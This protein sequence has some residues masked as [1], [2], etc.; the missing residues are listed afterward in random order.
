MRQFA[1]I[2]TAM[3]ATCGGAQAA[4]PLRLEAQ[5]SLTRHGVRPPTKAMPMPV[6]FA[7]DAWPG[8]P[9][10]PGFLTPHGAKAM[11]ELGRY[12]RALLA[13]RGLASV[14][15]C[16]AAGAVS[17]WADV[18]ERTIKSAEAWAQGFAPGCGLQAGHDPGKRDPLFSPIA[19]GTVAVDA[20]AAAKA[21]QAQAASAGGIEAIQA[22]QRGTLKRLGEVYGCCTAPICP[23]ASACKLEDLPTGLDAPPNQ[24]PKL[25]GALDLASTAAQIVL[26]EYAD[27]RPMAEVG[28]G[29][30]SAKDI[31]AFGAF[32]AIEFDLLARNPYI[33]ARNISPIAARMLAALEAPSSKRGTGKGPRI[34]V[35]LGHDTNVASLG[36]LLGLHWHIPGYA[37]DDPSP[38]GA[39]G[40]ERLRDAKGRVFVRAFY[41]A[42]T[43]EQ[44]RGLTPLDLKTPP[45][46]LYL[47]LPGCAGGPEQSCPLPDF[48]RLVRGRIVSN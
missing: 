47:S 25:T 7:A 36:G 4:Q 20:Q 13:R 31:E 6:G 8:F 44:L 37:P 39:L 5:V 28:W 48:A 40:F 24:R 22:A 15:G 23:S 34:T 11:T 41:E 21:V 42:Q 45:V 38:G 43:L 32:H 27:G 33:A 35:L 30:A 14:K 19:A 9:V 1:L 29:R 2:L 10:E 16:P 18:D 3:W 12:D 46:R 26:L 17:L